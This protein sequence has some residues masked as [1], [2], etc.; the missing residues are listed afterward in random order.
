MRNFK[1]NGVHHDCSVERKRI[2][3]HW[4]GNAV[5]TWEIETRRDQACC[6]TTLSFPGSVGSRQSDDNRT[7]GKHHDK[8]L[9]ST[10]THTG[11]V[12]SADWID[13]SQHRSDD[14]RNFE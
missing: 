13:E 4:H 12:G 8:T 1:G 2:C 11:D 9:L 10:H 14:V 7:L 3:V 5:G 6:I